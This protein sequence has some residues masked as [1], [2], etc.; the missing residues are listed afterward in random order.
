VQ[1]ELYRQTG[2]VGLKHLGSSTVSEKERPVIV[3]EHAHILTFLPI[4]ANKLDKCAF[5]RK[6][7]LSEH[8]KAAAPHD[9]VVLNSK[10]QVSDFLSA[11]VEDVIDPPIPHLKR[12]KIRGHTHAGLRQRRQRRKKHKETKFRK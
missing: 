4:V 9:T 10:F 12:Q 2:I 8:V 5:L 11:L 6:R 3:I 1:Y 7:K